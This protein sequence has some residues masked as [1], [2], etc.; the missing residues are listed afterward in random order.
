MQ[1]AAASP[2]L[3]LSLASVRMV[4]DVLF[5]AA[6]IL[7]LVLRFH[8]RSSSFTDQPDSTREIDLGYRLTAATIGART[9]SSSLPL[10]RTQGWR[11]FMLVDDLNVGRIRVAYG[12]MGTDLQTRG[13]PDRGAPELWN[14]EKPGVVNF[15]KAA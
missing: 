6:L 5:V 7:R 14:G 12:A 8:V 11:P 1:T 2:L 15:D 10:P 13:L 3:L 9:R 4:L